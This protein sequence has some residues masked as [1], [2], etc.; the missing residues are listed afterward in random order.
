REQKAQWEA[1]KAGKARDFLVTIFRINDIQSGNTTTARQILNEAEQRIPIEFASQ[2]ELRDELLTAIE[3]VNRNLDR[4]IPAA[5]ILAAGGGVNLRSAR[6]AADKPVPQTLL[7]PDDRLTLAT[8]AHVQIVCLSNLRKERLEPG[9]DATIGRAG[10]SP[11]AAVRE[12]D[13]SVL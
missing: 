11:A 2:P 12:R 5:M 10:C 7:Y 4:T 6:G 1:A 9:R 8:N 13:D 3:N